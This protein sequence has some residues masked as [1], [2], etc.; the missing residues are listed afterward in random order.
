MNQTQELL[1]AYRK[2]NELTQE[3]FA[4]M[5][6]IHQGTYSAIELGKKNPSFDLAKRISQL[7]DIPIGDLFERYKI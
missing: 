6:N 4:K 7:T 1:V 3:A 5:L 2:K